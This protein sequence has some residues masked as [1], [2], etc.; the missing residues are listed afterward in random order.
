VLRRLRRLVDK[1]RTRHAPD[2]RKAVFDVRV[3][4]RGAGFVLVGQTTDATAALELS[5]AARDV[6]TDG[7]PLFDE[8]VQ[9]PQ[10]AL[11]EEHGVVLAA[12][13]P[14]YAEP[15][16]PAP[17]I[18]QLLMGMRVDMLERRADWLRVRAEDGY[19]GWVHAGYI[20]LGD[21]D[22][23]HR[24]ERGTAGEAVVSL[25]AE[26]VDEFGH[27]IMH[28]P[29]GA[30]LVRCAPAEYCLPDGS[31]GRIAAGGEI[32]EIDR[33]ADRFPA[34]GESVARTARRWLGAP[35]LWGGTT[36]AGV[37]CS[38][39]TQAIFWLHGMALPRDSDLQAT[40]G[41]SLDIEQEITTLRAG[42]LLF[43]AEFNCRIT[44]VAISL[45][46]ARIIHSALSRGGV[47]INDLDGDRPF[48]RRLRACYSQARRLLAD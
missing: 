43:F 37:D 48:E 47:A 24:W 27:R 15:C 3:E 28:V 11:A 9:L 13:C 17:Q 21:V 2:P 35:Y 25:G 32:I 42:D 22:W 41:A 40:V 46:G 36:P 45:G 8:I 7:L 26:V 39:F 14:V 44:H 31:R 30:R 23:A 20:G 4:R 12:A 38:G 10:P 29:W 33:L 1:V 6:V 5:A 34:R 16:L 19:L 18:S